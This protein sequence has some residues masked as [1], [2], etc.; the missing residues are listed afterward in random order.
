M[1][2][3][4]EDSLRDIWESE[5]KL[6]EGSCKVCQESKKQKT[7]QKRGYQHS[8]PHPHPKLAGSRHPDLGQQVGP[9]PPMALATAGEPAGWLGTSLRGNGASEGGRGFRKFSSAHHEHQH[10]Y[11]HSS[12]AQVQHE[13]RHLHHHQQQQAQ[14]TP[15]LIGPPRASS[16][17]PSQSSHMLPFYPNAAMQARSGSSVNSCGEST[18]RFRTEPDEQCQLFGPTDPTT[19]NSSTPPSPKLLECQ[20]FYGSSKYNV[21]CR[22]A[23]DHMD[24]EHTED[25]AETEALMSAQDRD[26]SHSHNILIRDHEQMTSIPPIMAVHQQHFFDVASHPD[27]IGGVNRLQPSWTVWPTCSPNGLASTYGR[28]AVPLGTPAVFGSAISSA[29]TT[30]NSDRSMD[31]VIQSCSARLASTN[32]SRLLIAGNNHS[33]HFLAWARGRSTTSMRLA[34]MRQRGPVI[35]IREAEQHNQPRKHRCERK[36]DAER[37][38]RQVLQSKTALTTYTTWKQQHCHRESEP[39][40]QHCLQQQQ[41]QPQQRVQLEEPG[42]HIELNELSAPRFH[43]QEL[44]P[45]DIYNTSAV[46]S[47][48]GIPHQAERYRWRRWKRR[49]RRQRVGP[50]ESGPIRINRT[51]LYDHKETLQG[52]E[53]VSI[54]GPSQHESCPCCAHRLAWSFCTASVTDC[55]RAHQLGIDVA[56][57]QICGTKEAP[58]SRIHQPRTAAATQTLL[59]DHLNQHSATLRKK[60]SSLLPVVPAAVPVATC[61]SKAGEDG[62]VQVTTMG[63]KRFWRRVGVTR[64]TS[65]VPPDSSESDHMTVV[66]TLPQPHQPVVGLQRLPTILAPSLVARLLHAGQRSRVEFV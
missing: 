53:Q 30:N 61:I 33:H 23:N 57:E 22:S 45:Q 55:S 36:R 39:Q 48:S 40:S 52:D 65:S 9:L 54:A 19:A 6:M 29:S 47:V 14:M 38:L 11:Q 18:G 44:C 66:P 12:P 58:T 35:T 2:R 51:R 34:A 59:S 62:I 13:Q 60:N 4:E 8:R 31:T 25:D 26:D 7:L 5:Q 46:C 42:Q 20:P 43:L 56:I 15:Q 41:K 63:L 32:P 49:R 27:T 24:E 28:G 3:D 50:I 37:L 16:L 17:G 10:T 1:I 21:T 64:L